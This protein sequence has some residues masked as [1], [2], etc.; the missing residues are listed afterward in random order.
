MTIIKQPNNISGPILL[1]IPTV[2]VK[3]EAPA[4][5]KYC[6]AIPF[7]LMMYQ[8]FTVVD[9]TL[10]I[11]LLIDTNKFKDKN[12]RKEDELLIIK[13]LQQVLSEAPKIFEKTPA[14]YEAIKSMI[15]KNVLQGLSGANFKEYDIALKAM[16]PT[17][18][19]VHY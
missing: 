16:P 1:S 11:S 13:L 3:L 12:A 6:W 10:L 7:L 9:K 5:T 14:L 4:G 19:R 2:E 18:A 8:I 15:D 17:K